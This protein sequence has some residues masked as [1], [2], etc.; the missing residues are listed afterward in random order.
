MYTL[1]MSKTM[2]QEIEVWYLIPAIRREV[3]NVLIA[4]HKLKQK[5]VAQILGITEAAISQY[6][7]AKRAQELKFSPEEMEQIK[8]VSKK[9]LEDRKNITKYIYDLCVAFRGNKSICELHKKFDKSVD[10]DCKIC[11]AM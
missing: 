5:E 7:K 2:P 6:I 11:S 4:E 8:Q 10:K 1:F 9:I 3:A